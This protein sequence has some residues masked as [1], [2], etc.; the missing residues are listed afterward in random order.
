MDDKTIK[1][2]NIVFFAIILCMCIAQAII[3]TFGDTAITP[4]IGAANNAVSA[5][6]LIISVMVYRE[7]KKEH[8]K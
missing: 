6:G 4:Y 5:T 7:Y 3:W 1:I 8:K 2:L